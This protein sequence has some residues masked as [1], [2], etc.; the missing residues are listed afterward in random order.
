MDIF[1]GH[2][3]YWNVIEMSKITSPSITISFDFSIILFFL[4][5]RHRKVK[6]LLILLNDFVFKVY[7]YVTVEKR[8]HLDQRNKKVANSSYQQTYVF[9]AQ[10]IFILPLDISFDISSFLGISVG[11]KA[12]SFL[13]NL[14]KFN[15]KFYSNLQKISG[16]MD[17]ENGD[18][19]M[20]LRSF[21][22]W[23]FVSPKN[24]ALS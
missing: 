15:H 22:Y 12:T 20:Y 7:N 24:A 1:W 21:I 23:T 5:S 8:K 17:G 3:V 6:R 14:C 13:W 16:W 11:P 9:C 18:L 4:T 10:D 19:W 2:A